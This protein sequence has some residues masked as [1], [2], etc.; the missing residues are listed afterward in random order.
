MAGYQPDPLESAN[1]Q[2]ADQAEEQV[3]E[4]PL[5]KVLLHNDDFT[6]MEFVIF[7]L[8]EVFQLPEP[9]A[10]AI[11]FLV[12]HIGVGLIGLYPFEIAEMK[13]QKAYAVSKT[14]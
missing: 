12:H 5:Y 6:P 1:V 8:Q 11:T 7:I 4:P 2:E 9:N 10:E 14:A 13:T 3:K